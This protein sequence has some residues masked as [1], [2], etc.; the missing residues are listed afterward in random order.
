MDRKT[1]ARVEANREAK[2]CIACGEKPQHKRECCIACHGRYISNQPKGKKDRPVY[3]A[4][5]IA[6][7]LIGEN[8]QG[9]RLAVN[10]YKDMA[11]KVVSS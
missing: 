11:E 5:C 3:E 10:P 1:K 9:Q 4:E 7:G 2:F 6:A 8:R